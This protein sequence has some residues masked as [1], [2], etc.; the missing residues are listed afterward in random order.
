MLTANDGDFEVYPY[1]LSE[2]KREGRYEPYGNE[3]VKQYYHYR[4]DSEN[5]ENENGKETMTG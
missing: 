3:M 4:S 2:K 1:G 5:G